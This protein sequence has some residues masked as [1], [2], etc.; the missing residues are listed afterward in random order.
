MK[1]ESMMYVCIEA[2][3]VELPIAM[4]GPTGPRGGTQQDHRTN[5]PTPQGTIGPVSRTAGSYLHTWCAFCN[6]L[7]SRQLRVTFF[8]M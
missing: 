2:A 3:F 4:G 1:C 6:Q 5:V 8:L 7:Y